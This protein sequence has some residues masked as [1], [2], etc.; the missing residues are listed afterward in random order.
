MKLSPLSNV[1][2]ITVC[3]DKYNCLATRKGNDL[4]HFRNLTCVGM[5]L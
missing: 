4:S 1:S 5:W 3:I 2:G